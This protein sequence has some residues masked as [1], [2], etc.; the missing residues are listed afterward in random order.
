M[1]CAHPLSPPPLYL[2]LFTSVPAA[3]VVPVST[4]LMIANSSTGILDGY[5]ELNSASV[6]LLGSL[7][8]SNFFGCT[9]S[10]AGSVSGAKLAWACCMRGAWWPPGRLCPIR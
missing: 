1:R 5:R 2:T 3:S 8:T 9:F 10:I 7:M 6:I 4:P